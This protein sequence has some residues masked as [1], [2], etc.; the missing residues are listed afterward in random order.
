MNV[1]ACQD[2]VRE[3]L[4]TSPRLRAAALFDLV[5][6]GATPAQPPPPSPPAPAA[7]A[8]RP[9]LHVRCVASGEAG[10]QVDGLGRSGALSGRGYFEGGPPED[11]IVVLA[12]RVA[13]AAAVEEL[14]AHELVHATDS[15]VHG[16]DLATCGGL[17]C[18]EVRAAAAGECAAAASS[19]WLPWARRRCIAR[20]AASSTAMVFPHLGARCVAAAYDMC[21]HVPPGEDP[22][23]P[24][25][26]L[27]AAMAAEAAAAGRAR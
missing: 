15:L 12:D 14:L 23:G 27:A 21:A 3:L 8:S 1:Q 4:A 5:L 26:P 7:P 25:S 24:G 16:L 22:A 19:S 11:A 13:A 2:A 10:Q 17:A 9:R 18:S 20:L 6:A